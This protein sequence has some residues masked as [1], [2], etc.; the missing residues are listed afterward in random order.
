MKKAVSI[1][2]IFFL[3]SG[4]SFLPKRSHLSE[5]GVIRLSKISKLKSA[6]NLTFYKD[7]LAFSLF[8]DKVTIF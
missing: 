4:F 8:C 1:L 2:A 7:I 5:D 6:K 3:I